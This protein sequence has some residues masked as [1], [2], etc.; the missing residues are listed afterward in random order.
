VVKSSRNRMVTFTLAVGL[1]SACHAASVA[2]ANYVTA[3]QILSAVAA[4]RVPVRSAEVE[5]LAPVVLNQP[6]AMLKLSHIEKSQGDSAVARIACANPGECLPFFVILHWSDAQERVAVLG[7]LRS[8]PVRESST[9]RISRPMLVRAGH[10]ATLLM[11]NG[12]MR[13]T[14]QI[15]CLQNGAM[16]E[17]IRISSL[18]HK[19]ITT[20]EVVD[21]GLLKGTL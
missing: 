20:A 17:E 5:F 4:A 1:A 15:I 7:P 3:D 18:D 10:A 19:R 6:D 16:G 11:Q 14:T 21:S 13:I 8:Q 9:P 12:T 2:P